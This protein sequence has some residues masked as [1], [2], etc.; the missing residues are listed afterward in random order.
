MLEMYLVEGVQLT[1]RLEEILMEGEQQGG[2]NTEHINEIFRVMHTIK[3][4][5]AMMDFNQISNLAHSLEDM[6][7]Y[8]REHADATPDWGEIAD[9]CLEAVD[10]F[11]AEMAKI[12]NSLPSDGDM[13]ELL[14]R[15]HKT[16][17]ALSGKPAEDHSAPPPAP[18]AAPPPAHEEPA[19]PAPAGGLQFRVFFEEGCKMENIRAY[20]IVSALSDIAGEITTV[21]ADLLEDCSDDI[22]KHGV[23]LIFPPGADEGEIRAAI[24]GALFVK[25]F[26]IE[27][28]PEPEP[29]K[30]AAEPAQAQAAEAPPPSAAGAPP[31]PA[32]AQPAKAPLPP[33]P[34]EVKASVINVN[35]DKL[36]KLMDLMGEIVISVAMV[37]GSPDL[38]GLKLDKFEKAASQLLKNTNELQ[39]I[40]MS[41]RMIPIS[42]PFHKMHRI[43]RDTAKKLEKDVEL[44]I[45][46]EET[47]VDKNIIDNLSDPLMHIVR[48]SMDHG[49]EEN[50][51]DRVAAGKSPTG[52]ITLEARNSGSDVIISC[53]DDGR[54]LDRERILA[55]ARKS[56]LLS[57]PESDYTEKDIYQFIMLAGF[58]TNEQV[59][60]L[61]GRGVGMDVVKKNIEKIGGT[62]LLDSTPGE[63]MTVTIRIPLTLAILQS[64]EIKVGHNLY[65]IPTLS[66]R[67]S[68]RPELKD[69]IV[70]PDGNEMILFR[71]ECYSIIRL[72]DQFRVSNA[73]RE[74]NEGVLI[75]VEDEGH[76]VGLFADE[77]VSEQQAVV[78]PIPS[79]ITE[80]IGSIRGIS[81]CTIMGNGNIDLIIDVKSLAQ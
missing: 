20:Q 17:E 19:P 30:P 77:L 9:I 13:S 14:A 57:R 31:A 5:A 46:G 70:D 66:I 28:A 29:P 43:V 38:A 68:F 42:S 11:K 33:V 35:V 39:N 1:E 22:I 27:A 34:T 72:A 8:I 79:F 55:K 65:L 24:S 6:F 80:R 2:F 3:G 56:N 51:E 47:E 48:N 32:A 18:A 40:I 44:V 12:Q 7:Y 15:C 71:G 81:G 67:E 75:M 26:D 50:K 60:E 52:R 10:F 58:S 4:S 41:V 23:L 25:S 49:I 76:M 16:L 62:V 64:I 73:I 61:S 59:T 74:F 78:K 21:P 54:G 63:G 45:L 53:T 69:I 36:D 37:V